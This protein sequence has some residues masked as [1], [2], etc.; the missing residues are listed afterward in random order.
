MKVVIKN[1]MQN[2]NHTWQAKSGF[3]LNVSVTDEEPNYYPPQ[4]LIQVEV[5]HSCG[6]IRL[7][8]DAESW[9]GIIM[10]QG[11]NDG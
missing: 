10:R 9:R 1:E 3:Y 7:P 11:V 2:C 6:A 5:C 4:G 8:S